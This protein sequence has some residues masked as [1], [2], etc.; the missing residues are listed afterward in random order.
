MLKLTSFINGEYIKFDHGNNHIEVENPATAEVY[1]QA[2][3]A[4]TEDL[5]R[6]ITSAEQGLKIWQKKTPLERAKI[7]NNIADLLYQNKNE[8]AKLEVIDTG[9]PITEAISDDIDSAAECFKY[10]AQLLEQSDGLNLFCNNGASQNFY[11]VSEPY[12]ICLGIGAWN[13]PLQIA[14]WKSA[15]CLAAGNSMIFKPS[16]LTP[17]TALKLAEIMIKAG[18]PKGLFNVVLGNGQTGAELVSNNKINKISLTGSVETGQ[19]IMSAAGKNLTPVTMELGGKSPVII[20]EDANL[21]LAVN[22]AFLANFYT[23]GEV[24]SNGTRVFVHSKI[25]DSFIEKIIRKAQNLKIGD[26]EDSTTEMGALIS[27]NHLEKVLNYINIGK[28]EGAK[29]VYGGNRHTVN[30]QINNSGY[31]VEPTIFTGC[32]DEMTIVKEEIFGPV[33][34]ILKFDT[35]EEVIPRANN[36]SYG[37]AAGVFTK[38]LDMAKNIAS[39]LQVGTCWINTYNIFPLDMPFGGYKMSGIGRE[40]GVEGIKSYLQTKSI[41]IN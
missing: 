4:L 19:N 26:P 29:L 20:L 39:Q 13:Y 40:N 9:K 25:Y 2:Q 33:M 11:T 14:A 38:N 7:F 35:V 23:Q 28:Q 10:Y 22:N 41:Y 18:V 5:E 34:S 36:S 27:S 30:N 17:V 6:A 15:P 12:G 16:E 1:A 31:F 21:E 24:C 32:T 3:V 8:L 37:L